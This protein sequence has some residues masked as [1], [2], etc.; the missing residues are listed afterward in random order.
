MVG[1]INQINN[2][3]PTLV[4]L[5]ESDRL[6]IGR[7][8][9]ALAQAEFL[10]IYP[11]EGPVDDFV[12]PVARQRRD[13]EGVHVLRV[14][15][16]AHDESHLVAAWREGRE[17]QARGLG[18]PPAQLPQVPGRYVQ[19]PV[20]AARLL[21]PHLARVREDQQAALV[22][23]QG[24]VVH[25]QGGV[26]AGGYEQIGGDVG[27]GGV[28]RHVVPHQVASR[29]ARRRLLRL[30]AVRLRGGD[31]AAAAVDGTGDGG[32]GRGNSG[33]GSTSRAVAPGLDQGRVAR[34]ARPPSRLGE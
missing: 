25:R 20:I 9:K 34:A 23:G 29:R 30:G 24:V 2:S 8:A 1:I 5:P 3:H 27:L 11:I 26:V 15:I 32:S 6:R 33:T 12:R 21:P 16:I 7:P 14:Q 18:V 31:A 22:G 10:L 17:H 28:R 19:H 13:L 4:H